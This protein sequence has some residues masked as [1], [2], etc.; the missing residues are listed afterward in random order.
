V[1][2]LHSTL[3]GSPYEAN[4]CVSLVS[5]I[6]EWSSRRDETGGDAARN[7]CNVERY[8]EKG[9]ER[10]LTNS[11]MGR[12]GDALTDFE[13]RG[14]CPFAASAIRL[15]ALTGARLREIL[16]AKW[17]EVDLGRGILFL[18]D[19]KTGAKPI[20]LSAAAQAVLATMQA[21]KSTARSAISSSIL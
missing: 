11:E 17:A 3:A 21:R 13:A 15:L 19:S 7:P 16:D 18:R 12:L 4:R 5:S 14:G 2:R 10:F 6:W 1:A 8:P 9:R 20:Y